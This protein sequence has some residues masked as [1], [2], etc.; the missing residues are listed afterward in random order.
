MIALLHPA[1]NNPLLAGQHLGSKRRLHSWGRFQYFPKPP[2]PLLQCL[3]IL[4]HISDMGRHP[5]ALCLPY[6]R[7]LACAATR[8]SRTGEQRN[9]TVKERYTG[10]KRS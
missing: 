7:E 5:F 1:W 6:K 8:N 2:E 3:D 4:H 9:E 10:V